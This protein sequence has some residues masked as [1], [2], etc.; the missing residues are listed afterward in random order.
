MPCTLFPLRHTLLPLALALPL[1]SHA[2]DSV[3]SCHSDTAIGELGS[4]PYLY[5]VLKG[6]KTFTKTYKQTLQQAK[7]RY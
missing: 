4:C 1:L 5:E 6:D 2:T 7:G 3:L